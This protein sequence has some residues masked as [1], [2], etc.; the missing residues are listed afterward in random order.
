V[1]YFENKY[2]A[3]RVYDN[4]DGFEVELSGGSLDMRFLPED[5]EL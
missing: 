5:L 1:I 3:E 4:F 2:S